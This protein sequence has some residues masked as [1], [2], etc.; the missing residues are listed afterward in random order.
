MRHHTPRWGSFLGLLCISLSADLSLLSWLWSLPRVMT[1]GL[2]NSAAGI[3]WRLS[4]TLQNESKISIGCKVW[5]DSRGM[6]CLWSEVDSHR[7]LKR[8]GPEEAA[9][10]P[11]TRDCHTEEFVFFPF[12]MGVIEVFKQRKIICRT[13]IGRLWDTWEDT[14]IAK[15]NQGQSGSYIASKRIMV[16]DYSF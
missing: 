8:Q 4:N 7:E 12:I 15:L 9:W 16:S 14:A 3:T 10:A 6:A 13:V 11:V 5:M 2:R 1:Q